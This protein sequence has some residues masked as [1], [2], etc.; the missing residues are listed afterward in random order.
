MMFDEDA[1][2]G[3]LD[4]GTEVSGGR[5]GVHGVVAFVFSYVNIYIYVN[6]VGRLS[7]THMFDPVKD[8]LKR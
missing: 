3:R 1:A 5:R 4:E 2:R 6:T 7:L 8:A